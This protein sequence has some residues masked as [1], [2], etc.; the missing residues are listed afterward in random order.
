MAIS[1]SY[2]S[3]QYQDKPTVY[4]FLKAPTRVQGFY[5]G[6]AVARKQ[7]AFI[8]ICTKLIN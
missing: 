3:V 5:F 7:I 4:L 2:C 8:N 1:R 6:A